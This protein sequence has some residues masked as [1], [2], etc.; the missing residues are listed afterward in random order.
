MHKFPVWRPERGDAIAPG[1]TF[2]WPWTGHFDDIVGCGFVLLTR[3]ADPGL[4]LSPENAAFWRDLGGIVV[5]FGT[6]APLDTEGT[7]GRWFAELD[8]DAVLIRPDFYV[9]AATR[10]TDAA[11]D[12][13]TALAARV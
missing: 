12:L 4:A 13:V 11:N 10:G 5:G 2:T 8:A 7:Y 3:T 1:A 9:F 6:G